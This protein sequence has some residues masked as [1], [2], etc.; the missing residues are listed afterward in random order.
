MSIGGVLFDQL[1]P[2]KIWASDGVGVWN[3]S[4]PHDLLWNTPIVWNSQS[5]GIEQLVANDIIV[6][7]G[8]HPILASWDRAFFI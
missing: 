4:V 3:T 6:P 5:V 2:N 7:P 1:V 8:G